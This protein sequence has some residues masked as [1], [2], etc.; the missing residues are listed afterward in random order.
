MAGVIKVTATIQPIEKK[1]FTVEAETYEESRALVN[2]Q[3]PK[4]WGFLSLI[5]GR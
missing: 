5:T 2:A 3:I 4:G 1:Q